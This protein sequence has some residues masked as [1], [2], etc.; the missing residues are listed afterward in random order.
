MKSFDNEPHKI[1]LQVFLSRRGVCSRRKAFALIREGRVTI[2]G[3]VQKEPSTPID[4][5]LNK[6]AVDGKWIQFKDYSYLILH[7]PQ[8][9][10]TTKAQFPN[11]KSVFDLLPA[12]YRYLAPVGRLDKDSEGLLLLTNDGDLAYRLTHPRFN[13]DKKYF[14]CV[15]GVL[16]PQEKNQLERGIVMEG[17]KTFPAKIEDVKI[18]KDRTK[19]EFLLTIHEGKK[20]Q[21]RRMCEAVGHKVAYLKRLGQG[22]LSLGNLRHGEWRH[23]TSEEKKLIAQKLS[24]NVSAKV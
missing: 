9:Y 10:V 1:R 4:P 21:I 14:V 12:E 20:R 8:G 23:L 5:Q 7:K 13:V 18:F 11:E 24:A 22:P 6:V 2:N 19:T 16:T 17:E 3:E 15:Y